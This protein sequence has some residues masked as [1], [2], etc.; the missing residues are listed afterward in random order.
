M[1]LIGW[2]SRSVIFFLEFWSVLSFFDFVFV[3]VSACLLPYKG[4]SL[5]YLPGWD[6]PGCCTVV[7]Y[8]GEGSKREHC[9]L[10]ALLL[11]GFQ[12]LPLLPTSKLGSSGADSW[13]GGFM[14][15]LGPCG[16]VQR[17]LLWG[18]EFLLLPQLPQVFSFRGFEALFTHTG[19]L[20][21]VVCL[22]P[23]LFLLVY[24]HINVGPHA[25]SATASPD[26]LATS[27][28]PVLCT[29]AAHLHPSHQSGWMFLL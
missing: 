3:L 14:Y 9:C 18:S 26:P 15:V 10:L 17:T 20:G 16:S 6:N 25:L 2:L 29:L 19:T 5:R 13:V 7:L 12:W 11:A 23:Q 8:V 1:H 24:L 22:V 27:L 4:Q 28:Q 21:C